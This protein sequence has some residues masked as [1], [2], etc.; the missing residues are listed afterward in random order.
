MDSTALLTYGCQT[1]PQSTSLSRSQTRVLSPSARNFLRR[2]RLRS[3]DP[4]A[5]RRQRAVRTFFSG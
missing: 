2:R 4:S 1:H 5:H 3:P